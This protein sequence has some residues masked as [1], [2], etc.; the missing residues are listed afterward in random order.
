MRTYGDLLRTA[1]G[2]VVHRTF[3]DRPEVARVSLDAE[4]V[5]SSVALVRQIEKTIGRIDR[6]SGRPVHRSR[7]CHSQEI[8]A[9]VGLPAKLRHLAF[10]IDSYIDVA[11]RSLGSARSGLHHL[12]WSVLRAIAPA[13]HKSGGGDKQRRRSHTQPTCD[14]HSLS[15]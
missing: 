6:D 13:G 5:D 8:Q 4:L 1:R 10:A 11:C 3:A 14:S 9:P 2:S 12:V 15:R 7:R